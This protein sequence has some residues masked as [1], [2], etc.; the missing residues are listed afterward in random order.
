VASFGAIVVALRIAHSDW[1]RADA[2]R[3]DSEK[4]QAR[5]VWGAFI[6]MPPVANERNTPVGF[7]IISNESTAPVLHASISGVTGPVDIDPDGLAPP[8]SSNV[9]ADTAGRFN[10]P[11]LLSDRLPEAV[12]NL[13][14]SDSFEVTVRFMDTNHLWWSRTGLSDPVRTDAEGNRL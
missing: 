12:R 11:E 9:K 5:C 6:L 10:S 1:R 8:D 3:R 2:E 13:L 14:D 7:F 4:A